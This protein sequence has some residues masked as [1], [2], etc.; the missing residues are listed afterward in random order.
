MELNTLA[1]YEYEYLKDMHVLIYK[2][3]LKYFYIFFFH[4]CKEKSSLMR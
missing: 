2:K 3:S 4:F 1:L